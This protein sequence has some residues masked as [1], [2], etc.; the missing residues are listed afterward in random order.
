MILRAFLYCFCFVLIID[1][2]LDMNEQQLAYIASHLSAQECYKLIAAL[3]HLSYNLPRNLTIP[4]AGSKS[5][6]CK[7]LLSNYS[8]GK[9]PWEGENKS[10]EVIARR[11]RQIGRY[12]LADWLA[13]SVFH[14]LAKGV[15][16]S[17]LKN[18]FVEI[19]P[20]SALNSK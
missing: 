8:N 9:E 7:N 19:R 2:I 18:P 14:H 17:L 4:K 15:N 12:D 1:G 13:I 16:D 3:H 6:S 11:L 5:F 20:Q 10:H